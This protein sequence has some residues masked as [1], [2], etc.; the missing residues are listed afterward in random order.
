MMPV[1]QFLLWWEM[2]FLNALVREVAPAAPLPV[3]ITA[4]VTGSNKSIPA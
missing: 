4:M 3:H 1:A 2:K